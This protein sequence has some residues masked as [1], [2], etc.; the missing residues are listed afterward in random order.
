MKHLKIFGTLVLVLLLLVSFSVFS[1]AQDKKV[2]VKTDAKNSTLSSPSA[3]KAKS[4]SCFDTDK[5]TAGKVLIKKVKEMTGP[6]DHDCSGCPEIIAGHNCSGCPEV[7]AGHKAKHK[8]EC[9]HAKLKKGD[10]KEKK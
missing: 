4:E 2:T 3:K 8:G 9:E 1:V 5:K 10:K 7:I 6:K